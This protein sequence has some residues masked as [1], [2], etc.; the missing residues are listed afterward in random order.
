Q[1]EDGIRDRNVTGVQTCALPICPARPLDTQRRRRE[2]LAEGIEGPEVLI[3]RRRQ[4][5]GGLVTT[6]RGQVLPEDRVVD[7][8]TEVEGQILRQLVHIGEI[9]RLTRRRQLLQRGVGTLDLGVLVLGV[10]RSEE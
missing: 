1:A 10:V 6:L 4:L 9:A 2:V 5:T 8:T 3:D 7:M